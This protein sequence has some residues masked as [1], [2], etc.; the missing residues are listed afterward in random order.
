[1][2]EFEE[3]LKII[4]AIQGI[5]VIA[6]I[7]QAI[8]NLVIIFKLPQIKNYNKLIFEKL[9]NVEYEKEINN[10]NID[11]KPSELNKG[12][13]ELIIATMLVGAFIVMLATLII[14]E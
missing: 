1:M 14:K 4:I 5:L 7:I 13:I 11:E 2:P 6:F 3:L 10:K 9:Y 12:T 8:A